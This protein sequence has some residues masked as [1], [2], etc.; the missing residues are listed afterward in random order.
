[1]TCSQSCWSLHFLLTNTDAH[2]D[3]GHQN[4]SL[5]WATLRAI[6]HCCCFF[7]KKNSTLDFSCQRC[8]SCISCVCVS[9]LWD[10]GLNRDQA[11]TGSL[12]LSS[13]I[14]LL[15][16]VMNYF[17]QSFPFLPT[18]RTVVSYR[19]NPTPCPFVSIRWE[20]IG[21]I[22]LPST[23]ASNQLGNTLNADTVGLQYG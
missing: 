11:A 23:L 15:S 14:L 7:K 16:L 21:I 8:Q 17:L 13:T 6:R 5:F 19:Q 20:H 1:M 2:S 12:F 18:E 22:S 4:F 9:T 3:S 10:V